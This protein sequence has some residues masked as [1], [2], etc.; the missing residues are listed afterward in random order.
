[1]MNDNI[2]N[3]KQILEN[4]SV[5]KK[6]LL[7]FSK[8]IPSSAVKVYILKMLGA[9]VGKG[10]YMGPDSLILSNNYD[11][12]YIADNVFIAPGVLINVNNLSIGE[13]SHIG[14]QCLLVGNSLK[15]GSGCNISN[16]TFIECSYASINIEDG[17]TIA[18]GV[19]I[20]SHDGAYKQTY[21]LD[22]KIAPI[23]I[24]KNAFIGNNA[25]IL[26]GIKIG[27]KAIIGAGAV[28]TKNVEEMSVVGGVPAT[29]IKNLKVR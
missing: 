17:V 1:M 29:V 18:S 23:L 13:N 22:M 20:S 26:P 9:T 11:D 8:Y 24:E 27:T 19:V 3:H 10:V 21:D 4:I 28:V 14:Y 25:I 6:I 16:R 15:I 7:G 5:I 2:K 12:I